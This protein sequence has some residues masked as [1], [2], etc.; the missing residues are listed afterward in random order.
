MVKKM[1]KLVTN[2]TK[3]SI[4]PLYFGDILIWIFVNIFLSDFFTDTVIIRLDLKIRR[5]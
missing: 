5:L 3:L 4:D 1:T 2:K